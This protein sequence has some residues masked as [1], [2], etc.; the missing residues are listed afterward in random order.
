MDLLLTVCRYMDTVSGSYST[1][2]LAPAIPEHI[3]T[4]I[5]SKVQ[6]TPARLTWQSFTEAAVGE[7]KEGTTVAI[8]DES[9]I[10]I[11]KCGVQAPRVVFIDARLAERRGLL[12]RLVLPDSFSLWHQ[13]LQSP[14]LHAKQELRSLFTVPSGA[15]E[16]CLE[17]SMLRATITSISENFEAWQYK[18]TVSSLQGNEQDLCHE[19]LRTRSKRPLFGAVRFGPVMSSDARLCGWWNCLD[20][21]LQ[22]RQRHRR[23]IFKRL[24]M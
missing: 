6:A 17:R 21:P 1:C 2:G 10:G 19:T 4:R 20:R 12:T 5:A 23:Y 15:W 8:N 3:L 16:D 24:G 9:G 18:I 14:V 11:M 22:V 13:H 7:I